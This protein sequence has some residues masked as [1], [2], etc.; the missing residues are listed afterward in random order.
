M[1][2]DCIVEIPKNRWDHSLYFDKEKGKTGK[3]YSKW[4]GF[5][6]DVDK[7]DPLFFNITPVNAEIMDPQ[8]R[9][10]LECVYETFE[11]AGYVY[12]NMGYTSSSEL[13]RNVGV[14][15]GL[16]Y[17]E[18]QLFGGE[19]ILER[20][21]A[22]SN[23]PASVANR[24]SHF[25]DLTGPSMTINT[26]CS[27]SLISVHMAYQSIRRKECNLA[28]A[29]GVNVSVHPNKYLILAQARFLSSKG[30][31]E[32]FGVG[33]DGYVP[34]EGVGAVL[35]KPLK[36]AIDDGDHIYGVIKGSAINHDGRTNGYTVP[37]PGAQGNVVSQA[38]KDARIN[39]NR[40]SYIE[41][42]GTGTI[43]GDPIEITGLTKAFREYTQENQFQTSVFL[44][45]FYI[46]FWT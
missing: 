16:M 38:L 25:F 46:F 39:P 14:F 1:G 43:L 32:S 33:G 2:K 37:N 21:A 41:A 12:G 5:I 36:D 15:V 20:S 10:F 3:T 8:E 44:H 31:C 18:Y 24:A 42:H 9:L 34:S 35:L 23:S 27:S 11:D 6:D 29:G 40:I 7:F 28:I 19:T 13:S 45:F 17:E 26:M 4:V 30:K 22:L